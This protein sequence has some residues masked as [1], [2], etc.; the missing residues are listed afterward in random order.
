VLFSAHYDHLGIGAHGVVYPGGDD[1]ASGMAVLLGLARAAAGQAFQHTIL[2]VAFGAEEEG[3]VGSG[4]YVRDPIWPLERTLAV[5][6]FDMV[7][8]SFLEAAVDRDGAAAVVGLEGGDPSW[9]EAAE[10]AARAAGLDLVP[11]PARLVELFGGHDRTDDWW[12]RRRGVPSI[13]FST[14]LHDDYHRPTD[15][16]DRLVPAQMERV[17]RTSAGLLWH[18]ADAAGAR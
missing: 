4:I 3:L 1:N 5:I 7:G 2:F 16:A 8:R 15:T 11:A 17:A 13:H 10:R 18:L 12:F 14:G 9:R 6:N